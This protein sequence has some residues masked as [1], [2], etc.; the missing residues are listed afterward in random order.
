[1]KIP[2]PMIERQIFTG[3]QVMDKV[4]DSL[5]HMKRRVDIAFIVF[6]HILGAPITLSALGDVCAR[7]Y[8]S[9]V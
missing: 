5:N 7:C 8:R 2:I 9:M 4:M 1:M 3:Y 6:E